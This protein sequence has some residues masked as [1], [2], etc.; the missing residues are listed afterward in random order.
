MNLF[1]L[2]VAYFHKS[3]SNPWPTVNVICENVASPSFRFFERLFF[4]S[5]QVKQKCFF[6]HA[7]CNNFVEGVLKPVI[8][9]DAGSRNFPH[10]SLG[11]T[12]ILAVLWGW[13]K[14]RKTVFCW[15]WGRCWNSNWFPQARKRTKPSSHSD[16]GNFERLLKALALFL[17]ALHFSS[18][19]PFCYING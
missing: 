18:F 16:L 6:L 17:I 7:F 19:V 4:F 11:E 5:L 2:S 12:S 9:D 13:N 8:N 1:A 10:L 15:D 3:K 14:L